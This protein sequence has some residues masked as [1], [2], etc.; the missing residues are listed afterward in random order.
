MVYRSAELYDLCS[1][2]E[3][4]KRNIGFE[5]L[6]SYLYRIAY[7]NF[8]SQPDPD[9]FAQ[10]ITQNA[11]V[12]IHQKIDTCRSPE[13]FL[14]WS[15]QITQNLCIDHFRKNKNN[16]SLSAITAEGEMA[17]PDN[18]LRADLNFEESMILSKMQQE[19]RDYLAVAPISERSKRVVIGRY[20]DNH[21]DEKLAEIE[22]NIS[23]K[24]VKPSNIQV[25]RAK[26]I[27]K[28]RKWDRLVDW[29]QVQ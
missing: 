14:G 2:S 17:A 9:A 16:V 27:D 18:L 8:H 10:D 29:F 28:L 24:D 11:I 1:S 3:S 5:A 13:A 4:D 26:N 22:A 25:T 23:Q 12:R 6:W 19:F 7:F 21:I 15:R 20:F